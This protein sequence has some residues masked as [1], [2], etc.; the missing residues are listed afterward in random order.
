MP[1]I[2]RRTLVQNAAL[3][4]LA[5]LAAPR[6]LAADTPALPARP[7]VIDALS[8]LGR[9][10]DP[11]GPLP[12][13]AL[14][15][16]AASAV[17]AVNWTVAFGT[18]YEEAIGGVAQTLGEIERHRDRLSLVQRASDIDEA[19]SSGKVG[20][21]LGFQNAAMLGDELERLDACHGLGIRII[22]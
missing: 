10:G 22:R 20:I 9:P 6:L 7:L 13:V 21:I 18:D 14:D 15:D 4:A 1:G 12:G 2:D 17:A 3:G 5:A 16:A 8:G 11:E 19:W